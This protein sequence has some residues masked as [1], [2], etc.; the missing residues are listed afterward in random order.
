[1]RT[2]APRVVRADVTGVPVSASFGCELGVVTRPRQ[3]EPTATVVGEVVTDAGD[4]IRVVDADRSSVWR[5]FHLDVSSD[6][7][8]AV[9]VGP[10]VV[11]VEQAQEGRSNVE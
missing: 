2:R 1:M 7:T 9:E 5:A 3:R 11:D 10:A 8:R 6:E 4:R